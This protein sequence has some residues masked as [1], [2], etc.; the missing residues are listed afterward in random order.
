MIRMNVDDVKESIL[1]GIILTIL[2][3]FLFL[4]NVRST[5]ITGMALPNS[6]MGAFILMFVA[7]FS[8]N[9]MSLLALSLSVGLLVDDAIVVRENIFRYM[10]MGKS[11]LIAAVQGT[12]Q[13]TLAV[14]AT[15]LCVIAVF[16]PIGFLQGVVGQFFKEFGL[17]ICFT[18]LGSYAFGV[19][20]WRLAQEAK[21][22]LPHDPWSHSICCQQNPGYD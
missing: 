14:I 2:V 6:L 10:E 1:L 17:T 22:T 15:T 16:G 20:C 19:S 9:V 18:M 3:V 8:I 21:H 7:G 5:L 11:P 12:K 13:V 4:G